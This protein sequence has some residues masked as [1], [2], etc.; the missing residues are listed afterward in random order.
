MND[1]KYTIE[2]ALGVLEIKYDD[3]TQVSDGSYGYLFLLVSNVD[4]ANEKKLQDLGF[5]KMFDD[6][7]YKQGEDLQDVPKSRLVEIIENRCGKEGKQSESVFRD[8]NIKLW[9]SIISKFCSIL[10]M[11]IQNNNFKATTKDIETVC[12]FNGFLCKDK[13]QLKDFLSGLDEFLKPFVTDNELKQIVNRILKP[14]RSLRDYYIHDLEKNRQD[15][16]KKIINI[17][18]IY[19]SIIGKPFPNSQYDF[20]SLQKKILKDCDSTLDEVIDFLN[21]S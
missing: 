17:Q 12:R 11:N 10:E 16:G 21:R 1:E 4:E 9:Q 13:G 2:E 19:K 5:T 3:I 8:G 20:M 18:N 14:Y 7:W 6:L 15:G